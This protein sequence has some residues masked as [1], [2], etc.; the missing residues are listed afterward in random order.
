VNARFPIHSHSMRGEDWFPRS[1]PW[2]SIAFIAERAD[3]NHSQTLDRLAER[4]GLSPE[5]LWLAY[6]DKDLGHLRRMT[7]RDHL[8]ALELVVRLNERTEP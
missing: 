1:V 5:E 2:E 6:N 3:R 4:G 7:L 8:A